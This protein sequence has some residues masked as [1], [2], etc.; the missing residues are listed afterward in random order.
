ME[1]PKFKTVQEVVAADEGIPDRYLQTST[2][3]DESQPLN[4]PVPEMDIPAI[5]LSLLLS[6]SEDGRA[7]L[8]KLHSALSTWGVVQVMNHGITEAFLDNIYKLTKEFFALPTEEKQKCAR[9]TGS[10]QGYGNDMILWDDQVFDW[11]DRLYLTT[12]PEDQRK[13]KFWPEL[14]IGF[15]E[16]LDE[17]TMKQRVVVEKFFKAM[18]RSL[19]LEENSFLDM[20]GESA[21]MDTRF[22][23]Y[24]PCPRPDKVIGVKPHA[25]GSAFTLLLPDKD[26]EGLQFLKDGKWY[27]AP[28]VNDTI[29]IN[30]GDQM[31]IM[32]NGIYK[33][34][35][36]RVVTNSEKERISVATFCVPG[37]EKEIQPVE[38]LVSEARPRLYKTVKKYV[39]LYFQYY[40]QGRRPME[41]ALI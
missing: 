7:E 33:S 27:K 13:L 20:Y 9:D 29:L 6:A 36:H 32:S 18:A 25:D 22:N 41:A 26:V 23:M 30:I 2:G 17:Y 35:V 37:E 34:P 21:T 39:E 16:T 10:M 14:P 4:G 5:D 31:E 38:G 3:D 12:Y 24:P 11:I 1:K 8:S 15:R 19:E 28:I 40:Q